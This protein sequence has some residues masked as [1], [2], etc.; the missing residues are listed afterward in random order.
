MTPDAG[1]VGADVSLRA[2]GVASV[3]E[4][5]AP[6]APTAATEADSTVGS[7]AEGLA[8]GGA[9]APEAVSGCAAEPGITVALRSAVPCRSA[10]LELTDP[11][12]R[13]GALPVAFV[14]SARSA[15]SGTVAA[16]EGGAGGCLAG[17]T[18]ATAAGTL[19]WMRVD[20][21]GA[22][23][24]ALGGRESRRGRFAP[25][26]S[27]EPRS[28]VV[29]L[30]RA[31]DESAWESTETRVFPVFV[32][33]DEGPCRSDWRELPDDRRAPDSDDDLESD[34]LDVDD[35]ESDRESSTPA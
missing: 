21:T 30:P 35:R 29:E 19:G 6:V 5:S 14:A 22:P 9:A 15:T 7:T 18:D 2:W 32:E 8:A 31:E 4:A 27:L 24:S 28:V 3:W 1:L 11:V 26:A 13:G 33:P 23:V 16:L 25:L 34:D 10:E 17:A 12:R 20:S